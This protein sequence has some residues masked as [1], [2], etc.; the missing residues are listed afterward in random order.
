MKENQEPIK[1]IVKVDK[2]LIKWIKSDTKLIFRRF[3]SLIIGDFMVK[4]DGFEKFSEEFKEILS[5]KEQGDQIKKLFLL[6]VKLTFISKLKENEK[7]EENTINE[8]NKIKNDIENIIKT[9]KIFSGLENAKDKNLEE[10]IL[11]LI[12]D[13][14]NGNIK[15]RKAIEAKKDWTNLGLNLENFAITNKMK[16]ELYQFIKESENIKEKFKKID[17]SIKKPILKQIYECIEEY[18]ENENYKENIKILTLK[19]LNDK[20]REKEDGKNTYLIQ[21]PTNEYISDALKKKIPPNLMKKLFEQFEI[22]IHFNNDEEPSFEYIVGKK[23][24]IILD[25]LYQ[26]VVYNKND[27]EEKNFI[28]YLKFIHQVRVYVWQIKDEIK[29]KTKVILKMTIKNKNQSEETLSRE[30]ERAEDI[31]NLYDVNCV[32]SFK[33][34]DKTF[35]FL[36]QNVLV[37]GMYGK[38]PG[39]VFLFNELCNDDYKN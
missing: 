4:K 13:L 30:S 17:F 34:K 23:E 31:Y 6:K 1:E 25:G 7:D 16:S 10:I 26:D 27:L 29:F 18:V 9:N 20:E 37:Y 12:K 39:L 5:S 36:D 11:Y 38:I 8:I 24:T 28:Q 19:E 3:F 33:Y 35:E 22:N 2:K 15:G 21:E 14:L 32:S